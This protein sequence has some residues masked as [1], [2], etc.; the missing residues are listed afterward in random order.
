[1]KNAILFGAGQIGT[2]L[3]RLLGSEYTPLCFIDNNAPKWGTATLGLPVLKP[4]DGLK[5]CPE[6]VFICVLDDVRA[7][8]M[9]TQ[10]RLLGYSGELILPAALNIFDPRMATMRLLCEQITGL[11]IPGDAA[12]LGV[13]KGSFSSSINAALPDRTIHLFD[14]FEGF[15]GND[16]AVEQEGRL[17]KAKTGDFADTSAELVLSRLPHPEKA[18]IH[19]GYFPGTFS[20]CAAEHF[21]FVS[22]DADLYAPTAAALPLF[23]DRLSTGGVIMVHDV[24]STQFTGAKKAVEEFCTRYGVVPTPVCDLHGSVIL[25]K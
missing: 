16:I 23:W 13:Y 14:T 6:A 9:E 8:E 22:V 2:M 5:L 18:V 11:N 24:L 10:L 12:E 1:M 4:E 20:G 3:C 25:R 21:A 17:S 15:D 19:K 7:N